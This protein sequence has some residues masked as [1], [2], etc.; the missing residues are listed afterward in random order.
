MK[1]LAWDIGIK[2]L[3]YSLIDF[4]VDKKTKEIIDWG[5]VN[6]MND[7][8]KGPKTEKMCGETNVNGNKCTSKA[9]FLFSND[10]INCPPLRT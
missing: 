9:T 2:N 1:F 8:D 5:I 6:L 10:S 7:V 4:D 3:A